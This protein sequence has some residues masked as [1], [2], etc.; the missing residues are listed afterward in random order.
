MRKKFI[1][2]TLII[3]ILSSN[4]VFAS[5]VKFKDIEGLESEE[6]IKELA[7]K[8]IIEGVT[9]EKF[10]PDKSISRAEILT[11]LKRLEKLDNKYKLEG[12]NPKVF[13]DVLEDSWY[14]EAVDWA[15][16]G[17]IIGGVGNN[18]FLADRELN[19]EEFGVII[20]N[21][22]ENSNIEAIYI[23]P[24]QIFKDEE[25]I[26]PWASGKVN[27]MCTNN[28]L[29]CKGQ[30]FLPKA[31]VTREEAVMVISNILRKW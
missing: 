15:S 21:Y 30:N 26:S 25:S 7:S 1:I 8:A 2:L 24:W 10:M 29:L 13:S 11:I 9:E 22:L 20:Y 14:K 5:E 23:E 6:I 31:R 28:V 27:L 17:K 19:R 3:G 18:K 12:E 4:N 16:A